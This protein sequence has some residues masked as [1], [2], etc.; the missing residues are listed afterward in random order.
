MPK[1]TDQTFPEI[2]AAQ[3]DMVLAFLPSFEKPGAIFGEWQTPAGHF[4]Y[5]SYGPEVARF[6]AM[7]YEEN[8]VVSFDWPSWKEMALGYMD[9]PETL[10]EADLLTLRKLLTT[11]VRND[12]FVEGHLAGM[13]ENGHITAILRRLQ[14]IRQAMPSG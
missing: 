11:H 10:A 9:H 13:L 6:V 8:F 2:S 7:L 12:R 5:Y 14:T 4:P 3:M 1:Q